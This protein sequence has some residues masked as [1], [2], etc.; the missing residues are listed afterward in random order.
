TARPPDHVAGLC[1]LAGLSAYCC[2]GTARIGDELGVAQ[3]VLGDV[4][5]RLCGIY[6]RL[7]GL[8]DRG[9]AVELGF[10][11]EALR[12]QGLI[13]LVVV[14][15][16]DQL[17]PGSGQACARRLQGVLLVVGIER[18]DNLAGLDNT[19]DIHVPLDHPAIDA[20]GEVD[21]GLRLN[22]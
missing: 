15:G 16:L 17:R 6:L 14:P 19:A 1:R 9:K 11:N 8:E 5:L 21:F 10:G 18:G 7:S 22:I 2:Y 20:E 12:Q 4:Y 13:A 3:A